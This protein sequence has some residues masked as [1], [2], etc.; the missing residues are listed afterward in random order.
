MFK[1]I[2]VG[3]KK[4]KYELD[5]LSDRK[6][7]SKSYLYVDC[8]LSYV[9]YGC[10]LN[11][12]VLGKFYLRKGFERKRILT[13]RKWAKMVNRVNS[14]QTIH[15]LQNKV[16]FNHFFRKYIG[17]EWIYS[18]RMT[19]DD[20][21][22][23]SSKHCEAIVKPM[24]G[25]EGE[26][27]YC[28]KLPNDKNRIKSIFLDLKNTDCLIEEK[29]Q[30]HSDMV[31]GNKSVNTIRVYTIYGKQSRTP[32]V[33]KTVLRVGVGDSIVDNS[34]SGGCAYEVDAKTGYVI[35]NSY[36]ANGFSGYIHPNTN[37]CMLGVHIPYWSEVLDLCKKAAAKIP[38]CQ[39]IG[40]D[41][42]I[43]QSAPVLI[44][45]N[46]LPDLDMIEFVG[47]YGYYTTIQTFLNQ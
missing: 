12:Y 19:L 45:G 42:A 18:K 3:L 16:D 2:I 41:V 32:H 4:Y 29:I 27:I 40:W 33:L 10:V 44:E 6:N 1:S 9:R 43:T 15:L 11:H 14:P 28:L 13:Y 23:F 25:L 22:Q 7:V 38:E 31:F 46:H 36:A 47:S 8:F 21:L 20:F 34:H 30:Q 5:L 24:T 17:R 26:G 37:I 39:Y 35:S